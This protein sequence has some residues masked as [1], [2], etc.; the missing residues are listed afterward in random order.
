MLKII[1]YLCFL[2]L[3]PSALLYCSMTETPEG[4]TDPPEVLPPPP[5]EIVV[6]DLEVPERDTQHFIQ[7][8]I[9]V[10]GKRSKE[11][12][13]SYVSR[14]GTAE[15]ENDYVPV[16]GDLSFPPGESDTTH[17]I[18][19]KILSNS[20]YEEDKSFELYFFN[21]SNAQTTEELITITLLNDDPIHP[22]Y[23][24]LMEYEGMKL[25]WQDEFNTGFYAD[26][27]TH[28]VGDGCPNLCGWGNSQLQYYRS[29]NT[30]VENGVLTITAKEENFGGKKYTASRILSQDKVEF[31][32]GRVDIR[33]RLPKGKG[34]WPALWMLGANRNEIGWPECGEIDIMELRGS[35]PGKICGTL[36]YQKANG[37]HGNTGAECYILPAGETY[38]DEFHVF[39]IVWDEERITWY[40]DDKKFNEEFFSSLNFGPHGNPFQKEFYFLLNVAVGGHYD[41]NPDANTEFPQKMDIDYIR[42]FQKE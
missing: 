12:T 4:M 35:T 42:V 37:Q 31:R 40:L 10:K 36:H 15:A 29:Q 38:S 18:D 2:M 3:V 11:V 30:T 23:T 26:N 1:K 13:L 5:P 33:A 17:I 24:T 7:A 25:V 28:A 14:D 39:S 41:G 27:W 32:Y 34:I 16:W 8:E 22:G 6:A 20:F 9:T 19:I 21:I